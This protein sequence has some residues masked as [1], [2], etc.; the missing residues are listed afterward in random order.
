MKSGE[1]YSYSRRFFLK[2]IATSLL[3]IPF[4]QSCQ[5]K[6]ITL[7]IRLSGTNH[8]LGHRLRVKNFPKPSSQIHIPYLIVGG[9]ISGLSAAR[10]FS[11]KGINDFLLIELESHLGGNSSNGENKYSKFPL[12]AHYLPLPNKQDAALLQFLEEEKIIIG[13]D[14]KGFPKF[15]EEQLT[16]AP[17][18]RLFYKNNWQ[19]GLIPKIGNAAEDDIQ[20][21]KFFLKMDTFRTGKGADGKYF[22]D[23]PLSLSSS[24]ATIRAFDTITM[25]Q[26]FEEE[27]FNS[28]PLFDYIDY[29]CRDDFGLGISYVSA[30]AG[31]HYFAARK[32]DSTQDNKDNV[33]TWPEGNARLAHHLQKYAENKTL[34]NH[35]VYEVKSID[36][37]VVATVFDADKKLTIE[38]IADRVIMAT[39]QF[40]NQYLI[41]NRKIMTQNFHYAPWLLATLVVSDLADNGNYPLCWD[42][43]IYGANGLGYIYDQHQSLQ[44][45]QSKKVITYYYSFSSSDVK[46]S[47]KDLY[48]KKSTYWKQLVFDDLKIAHPNIE[49]VTEEI[50]IHLLG[51]GMI[52]PVP[53]FIFGKHKKEASQNIEGKIFFAHSDLSGISIF[54]EAF[55]QGINIVN[56]IIDGSTLD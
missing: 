28:K 14:S 50:N 53:G 24:E 7:L 4:L 20:F 18:E 30:W 32:Q 17:D 21:K 15:D 41:R 29:C 36:G 48:Q 51:H 31:I 8:I 38:I 27:G 56:Q 39:P 10:Q 19:E 23:I 49:S 2:G 35:L 47:R 12:G 25:Q 9:G 3:V 55:H 40:V 44:Q 45:V 11:K 1:N 22:F 52:S 6:V 33:L 37:K 13:Y 16:F 42:N 26:W 43:V 46:K 54:E 5:E 34:K